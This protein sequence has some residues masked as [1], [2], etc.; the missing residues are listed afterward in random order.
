[1]STRVDILA[2][3][4]E[5]SEHVEAHGCQPAYLRQGTEPCAERVARWR[6]YMG[7]AARWGTEPGDAARVAEQYAWQTALL[8]Q[9]VQMAG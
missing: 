7:T 4:A 9:R 6:A 3:K 1:M 2:A 8:G 5:Y